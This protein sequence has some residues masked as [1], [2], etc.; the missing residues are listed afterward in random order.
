MKT[1]NLGCNM[2]NRLHTKEEIRSK[3][4][5][6]LKTIPNGGREIVTYGPPLN[7]A[8]AVAQSHRRNA[9]WRWPLCYGHHRPPSK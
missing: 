8:S 2:N 7:N 3:L 6:K 5:T 4:S 1:I 9:I